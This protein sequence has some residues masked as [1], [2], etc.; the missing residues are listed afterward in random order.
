[1]QDVTAI[2]TSLRKSGRFR[3]T[4]TGSNFN[5]SQLSPSQANL[6]FWVGIALLLL[7]MAVIIVQLLPVLQGDPKLGIAK[8]LSSEQTTKQTWQNLA[9]ELTRQ[10]DYRGACR[11]WYLA[12][13]LQLDQDQKV[14]YQPA[15]TNFEY[16]QDLAPYPLLQK[17]LT[18]L[19]IIYERLW[20]GEQNGTLEE[21]KRCQEAVKTAQMLSK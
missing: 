19:I 12:L 15:R 8:P 9:E 6:I 21:V 10:G 13:I 11:A 2:I 4:D 20:Y 3:L 5:F 14:F 1:M 18:E 16:L 7:I 17:P